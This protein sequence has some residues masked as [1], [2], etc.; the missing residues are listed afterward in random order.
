[1]RNVTISLDERIIKA[2]RDYAHR[3]HTT[4]NNLIRKSLKNTVSGRSSHWVDE[5]LSLMDRCSVSRKG[6]KWRREE[7]YDR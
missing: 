7:L 5:C 4:L 6:K 1:M 3:Q 2:G